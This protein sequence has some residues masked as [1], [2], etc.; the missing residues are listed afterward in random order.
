MVWKSR[1][2]LSSSFVLFLLPSFSYNASYS[3]IVTDLSPPCDSKMSLSNE[4]PRNK[5]TSFDRPVGCPSTMVINA[6]KTMAHLP[7]TTTTIRQVHPRSFLVTNRPLQKQIMTPLKR[8]NDSSVCTFWLKT[9]REARNEK[10]PTH[11]HTQKKNPQK[12]SHIDSP[13]I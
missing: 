9:L 1:Q 12:N 4:P 2:Q 5:R 13:R 3:G 11:T 8:L 10:N 7:T 6:N